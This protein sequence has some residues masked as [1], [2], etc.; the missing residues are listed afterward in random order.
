MHVPR[1]L[2]VLVA[3]TVQE[4]SSSVTPGTPDSGTNSSRGSSPPSPAVAAPSS[5]GEPDDASSSPELPHAAS[6]DDEHEPRC[7]DPPGSDHGSPRGRDPV[8][9]K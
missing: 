4:I 9:E 5:A 6:R 8:P 7:D 3:I 1:G 2:P